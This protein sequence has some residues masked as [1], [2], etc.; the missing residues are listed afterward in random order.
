MAGIIDGYRRVWVLGEPPLLW[1]LALGA[2]GSF[3]LLLISYPVFKRL[4]PAF[5][6]LI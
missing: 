6:D 1:A 5:A 3:T 4:E 2:A